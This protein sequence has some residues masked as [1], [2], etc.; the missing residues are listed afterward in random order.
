MPSLAL[1]IRT[2][3]SRAVLDEELAYGAE[4]AGRPDLALRAE[5][6]SSRAE[7]TRI[8]DAL[9]ESLG[10][11]PMTI[12]PR[13]QRAVVRAAADDIFALALRLHDDRPAAIAGLAA[14][15]RL[16]GDRR[17]P[18][19]RD[20]AGDLDDAIRSALSALDP[21]AEWTGDLDARAA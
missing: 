16:A 10:S 12:L 7:R 20:D 13:P 11:E 15:A 17:G 5:Q 3:L 1:R 6:L 2:R 14:A 18:M 21:I 8:A 19:Y 4:P 9:V